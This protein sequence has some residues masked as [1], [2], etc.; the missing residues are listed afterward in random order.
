MLQALGICLNGFNISILHSHIRCCH[1]TN[2]FIVSSSLGTELEGTPLLAA[3]LFNH[4]KAGFSETV[5][6]L[7]AHNAFV[8]EP[9][10]GEGRNILYTPDLT[11][12]SLNTYHEG[13]NLHLSSKT[14]SHT[15]LT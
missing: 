2:F 8:D 12:L 7:L 15:P 1:P 5:D 9:L 13:V 3:F 10:G 6:L 14:R 4:G 11:M